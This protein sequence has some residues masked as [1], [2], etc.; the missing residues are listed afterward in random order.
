MIGIVTL[1]FYQ[2]LLRVMSFSGL[3]TLK[4]NPP[5]TSI[6]AST[7]IL[8]PS[9]MMVVQ[10]ILTSFGSQTSTS[11][12]IL[13]LLHVTLLLAKK[14]SVTMRMEL[15]MRMRLMKKKW[16]IRKEVMIETAADDLF[17]LRPV[18]FVC[19]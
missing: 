1:P 3:T 15:E 10:I 16:R 2:L 18:G 7:L 4:K 11:M 5:R 12:Y 17:D 8:A 14:S 19:C 13:P 6:S 9:A